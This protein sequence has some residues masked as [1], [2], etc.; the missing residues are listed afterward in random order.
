[1]KV[2]NHLFAAA[3]LML[4]LATSA[5]AQ[6]LLPP[7]PPTALQVHIHNLANLAVYAR[8]C[9]GRTNPDYQADGRY[10]AVIGLAINMVPSAADLML[11]DEVETAKQKVVSMGLNKFCAMGDADADM[12]T[13]IARIEERAKLNAQDLAAGTANHRPAPIGEHL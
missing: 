10:D 12:Q 2:K 7:A 9:K 4:S 1:M 3:A 13:L 6:L 11:H 5:Q 8:N